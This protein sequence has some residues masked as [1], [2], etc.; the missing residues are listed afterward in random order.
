MASHKP[1]SDKNSKNELEKSHCSDAEA[2]RIL[3]TKVHRLLV[4]FTV[5]VLRQRPFD[6][7]QFASEFFSA[8]RNVP[9]NSSSRETRSEQLSRLLKLLD[10]SAFFSEYDYEQKTKLSKVMYEVIVIPD[11]K[12]YSQGDESCSLYII[13]RGKYKRI[14]DR[15]DGAPSTSV[16]D[17]KGMLGELSLIGNEPREATVVALTGGVLWG[18]SYDDIRGTM[19]IALDRKLSSML[20]R[21]PLF[22]SLSEEERQNLGRDLKAR[23]FTEGQQII[24]QGDAGDGMYFIKS[25]QVRITILQDGKEREVARVGAGKYFGEVALLDHAVKRTA[26]VYAVGRTELA[27][28]DIEAF[29]RHLVPCMDIMKKNAYE[30]HM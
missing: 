3:K 25:G 23:V 19:H 17:E 5:D 18:L 29:D 20:S 10:S 13:E 30:Y 28:L 22:E 27:F 24:R 12:V 15:K 14:V 16:L 9:E 26:N 1:P 21:F 4:E 6:I 2:M 11:E 7:L 8:R